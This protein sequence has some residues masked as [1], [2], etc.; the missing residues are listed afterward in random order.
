MRPELL[1]TA[2]HFGVDGERPVKENRH[3]RRLR[4]A[5][6]ESMGGSGGQ[7]AQQSLAQNMAIRQNI[8]A[9]AI[10]VFQNVRSGSLTYT[11]GVPTSWTVL[12]SNVGLIRRFW[13]ELTG[14][15]NCA[16]THTLTP[17]M[18]GL[19]NLLSN[20]QFIDQNNRLRINTTGAHLHL[21]AG[22]KR[23]RPFGSAIYGNVTPVQ[24]DFA[25]AGANFPVQQSTGVV[26]GGTPKNFRIVFEIPVVNSNQDLT[27]AIYANQTTSN[28]QLQFTLNA[29]AAVATGADAFNAAYLADAAIATTLPT[30][31]NLTWTLY[32][33]FLDQLPV[34]NT[35]FAQLPPIDI[36]Y[37]LVYQMINPGPQVQAQD[38]LYA[39]P[40][41]NVYQDLMLFWDNFAFNGAGGVGSDVNYVKVQISNTYILLQQD[42]YVNAIRTR[43]L[44]GTDL[45][46]AVAATN[47]SGAVYD[48][49][50]R[51]KPLSVN[52]LSATNIV[53]NPAT[54]QS[55]TSNLQIGQEYIWYANQAAA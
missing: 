43:N 7:S 41:F 23:R 34:D 32:Q 21:A 49:D 48:L 27:G 33:D 24:T 29:N 55:A 39:L 18:F 53:F 6:F 50:F 5:T 47:T 20:V 26:T 31:T 37:A 38:N 54:V 19:A 3:F 45:P 16:A 1:S 35:G 8:L 10:P 30:I 25:G 44:M 40:P 51:H 11:A 4:N 9:N 36:A 15:V 12:A 28:N 13:L 2:S 22:Q 14:T 42:P 52:Q 46:G 17:S